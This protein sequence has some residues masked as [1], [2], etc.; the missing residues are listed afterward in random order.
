MVLQMWHF[1]HFCICFS[2]ESTFA[3]DAWWNLTRAS[4]RPRCWCLPDS[5]HDD[6]KA[7]CIK[8]REDVLESRAGILPSGFRW[9]R[10]PD[11]QLDRLCWAV[12]V[13]ELDDW[14]SIVAM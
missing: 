8:S 5:V 9:K 11:N 10:Q 14:S 12:S 7:V 4:A 6:N 2:E 3:N 1:Y 13:S